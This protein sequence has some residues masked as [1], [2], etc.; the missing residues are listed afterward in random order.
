MGHRHPMIAPKGA[1][2]VLDPAF[3]MPFGRRAKLRAKSPVRAKG[4]KARRF[5]PP[6]KEEL[7]T[8]IDFRPAVTAR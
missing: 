6:I 1:D 8:A 3:L 7:G 2:L 5:L 4:D